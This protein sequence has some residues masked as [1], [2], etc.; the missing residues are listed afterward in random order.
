MNNSSTTQRQARSSSSTYNEVY[1]IAAHHDICYDRG[2]DKH[3]YDRKMV[4]SLDQVPNLTKWR[5][6]AR[7]LIKSKQKLDL[8]APKTEEAVN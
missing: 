4:E 2:V 5:Q 1:E 3:E 7:F 8:G 6:T